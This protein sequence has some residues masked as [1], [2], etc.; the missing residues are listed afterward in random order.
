MAE[1]IGRLVLAGRD[2]T[3]LSGFTARV[4]ELIVVLRDL[5]KGVYERTMVTDT[6]TE[7]GMSVT[8]VCVSADYNRSVSDPC[9]N[10]PLIPG[11]GEVVETN[12][13]IRYDV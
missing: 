13:I 9:P 11:S 10:V 5:Q 2:L 7:D 12:H 1:A 4:Y 8:R 3:R 6:T